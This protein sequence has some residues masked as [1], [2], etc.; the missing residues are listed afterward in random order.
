MWWKP[1]ASE[2]K[3]WE[4]PSAPW[5]ICHGSDR[6]LARPRIVSPGA[7]AWEA[8]KSGASHPHPRSPEGGEKPSRFS[9]VFIHSPIPPHPVSSPHNLG[10][11]EM[12][13]ALPSGSLL[14]PALRDGLQ[15][16]C[17]LCLL[18]KEGR[19]SKCQVCISWHSHPPHSPRAWRGRED[20]LVGK[21]DRS[22]TQLG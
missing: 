6:W 14:D 9:S 13:E 7:A 1:E 2:R 3:I 12:V 8:G 20:L 19:T 22:W 16:C 10:V 18:Q 5:S 4:G 15:G 17:S 21:A 11:K